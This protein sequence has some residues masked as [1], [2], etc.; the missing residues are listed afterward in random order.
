MAVSQEHPRVE[1][2]FIE[3]QQVP[4]LVDKL[5]QAVHSAAAIWISGSF[6]TG[7]TRLLKHWL[8]SGAKVV[9]A[10]QMVMVALSTPLKNSFGD[11]RLASP[12]TLIA[13]SRLWYVYQH[14]PF[15]KYRQQRE[16]INQQ[17]TPLYTDNKFLD[18]FNKVQAAIEDHQ[19]RVLIIDNAQYLDIP[20]L[21]QLVV[22]R[23][24]CSQ[25]FAM[26]FCSELEEHAKEDD[27]LARIFRTVRGARQLLTNPLI[28][29]Y[30]SDDE[31]FRLVL[32]RLFY[33][34]NTR[35]AAEVEQDFVQVALD[36]RQRAQ[37]NWHNINQLAM[38][39]DQEL[40]PAG[41]GLRLVTLDVIRRV[42]ERFDGIH[43]LMR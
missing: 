37:G 41:N 39:F 25:P 13:F 1:M 42:C 5:N 33:G 21:E 28:I 15:Q 43:V 22:L 8:E 40:P 10:D 38:L 6:G 24:S 30:I 36:L 16:L 12:T 29:N 26:V 32:P 23:E 20:L 18:L 14:I 31:F 3:H 34:L 4:M 2:P 11:K 17:P 19:T 9:D 35:I 7:K 27:R